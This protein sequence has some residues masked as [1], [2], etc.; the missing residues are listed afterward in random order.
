M[1]QNHQEDHVPS[2]GTFPKVSVVAP[3]HNAQAGIAAAIEQLKAISYHELEFILVDDASSDQTSESTRNHI[4]HDGRFRLITLQ[5]NVGP[6][7]ARNVGLSAATGEYIWFCDWDDKWSPNI[8]STLVENA[9]AFDAQISI[10]RA[11]SVTETGTSTGVVDGYDQLGSIT[12]REAFVDLLEGTSQGYLWNKLFLK[13]SIEHLE[14]QPLPTHE[15]FHFLMR[16]YAVAT[17]VSST[18]HVL[19]HY[20]T[21]SGSLTRRREVSYVGPDACLALAIELS[22]QLKLTDPDQVTFAFRARD[23]VTRVIHAASLRD[24]PAFDSALLLL[25]G[26]RKSWHRNNIQKLP[27]STRLKLSALIA[28]GRA[29]FYMHHPAK[30]LLRR[31]GIK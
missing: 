24:R 30:M 10:C 4:R 2:A 20:V 25:R 5:T 21:R 16:A 13:K 29:Y 26:E 1:Q 27:K 9:I 18:H 7:E 28:T 19:Y 14:F 31:I 15:D 12:G 17:V 8:I 23:L 6:G 11:D 22:Q 3:I